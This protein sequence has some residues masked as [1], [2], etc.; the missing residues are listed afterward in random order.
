MGRPGAAQLDSTAAR[1]PHIGCPHV[2]LTHNSRAMG[3]SRSFP[4]GAPGVQRQWSWE[5][6]P[7]GVG[8]GLGEGEGQAGRPVLLKTLQSP[9]QGIQVFATLPEMSKGGR[10]GMDDQGPGKEREHLVRTHL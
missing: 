1:F 4:S 8:A 2:H 6:S 10:M 7:W 5:G 3:R 9:N